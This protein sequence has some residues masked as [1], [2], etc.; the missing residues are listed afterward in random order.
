VLLYFKGEPEVQVFLYFE[1]EGEV[2]VLLYFKVERE[3]QVL[4][5]FKG[6][7][8]VQVL[9]YFKGAWEKESNEKNR[10]T[11]SLLTF[12]FPQLNAFFSQLSGALSP[13]DNQFACKDNLDPNCL[14]KKK[15]API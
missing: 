10:K 14:G 13:Y 15:A 6:E 8:E 9:L 1:G 5:Y 4:L 11:F 2:Q 12:L 3:A 7:R